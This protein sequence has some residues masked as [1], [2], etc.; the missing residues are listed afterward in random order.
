MAALGIP[1]DLRGYCPHITLARVSR[2][3]PRA[4]NDFVKKHRDFSAAPFKVDSF[5]LYRTQMTHF[6]S[7][8]TLLNEFPLRMKHAKAG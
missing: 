5:C 3:N 6:G 8:Y 7:Q 1:F 4:V 2:A